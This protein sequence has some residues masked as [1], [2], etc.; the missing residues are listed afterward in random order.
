MQCSWSERSRDE[1][2]KSV[3]RVG[4][5]DATKGGLG[6][7]AALPPGAEAASTVSGFLADGGE[8]IA[9]PDIAARCR[10]VFTDCHA[11]K[12]PFHQASHGT[13]L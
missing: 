12:G 2:M 3:C 7:A 8:L 13:V 10:A 1:S 5:G 11:D 4:D 6:N 9:S